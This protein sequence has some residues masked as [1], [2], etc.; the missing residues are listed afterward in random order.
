MSDSNFQEIDDEFDFKKEIF[1]YF[2]FW[3]YFLVSILFF[4]FCAYVFN[5]YTPKIYDTTAKIQILDKKQSSIEMPSVEDLFSNSQINLENEIEILKSS[6]ILKKVIQNLNLNIYIKGN[7]DIMS[8]QILSYPF[9]I[10]SK[11]NTDSLK[12]KMSFNVILEENGL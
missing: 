3:K 12:I 1:K 9:K 8:S 6:S 5:R 10:T 4:L 7:G 11:I 2:F